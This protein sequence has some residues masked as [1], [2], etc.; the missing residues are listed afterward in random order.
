ML[1]KQSVE[2]LKQ[3]NLR[4]LYRLL[5]ETQEP[6]AL[7]FIVSIIHKLLGGEDVRTQNTTA[8]SS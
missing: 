5:R 7:L 6:R 8:K 1:T 4:A 2:D 3:Q